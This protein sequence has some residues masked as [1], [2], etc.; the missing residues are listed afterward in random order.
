M[1]ME[2]NPSASQ[3]QPEPLRQI[4]RSS[5]ELAAEKIA[6]RQKLLAMPPD[7]AQE[8]VNQTLHPHLWTLDPDQDPWEESIATHYGDYEE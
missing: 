1:V 5:A 6:A 7:E 3:S 4:D 8:L 2:Q